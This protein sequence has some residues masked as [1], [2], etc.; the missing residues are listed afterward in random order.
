M[1]RSPQHSAQFRLV[2]MDF[3]RFG[4]GLLLNSRPFQL[5]LN[6]NT[7][8]KKRARHIQDI[9]NRLVSLT[10]QNFFWNSS[11]RVMQKSVVGPYNAE[12]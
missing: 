12:L 2:V 8:Q 9:G 4:K 1:I 11:Q 7:L 6:W 10:S 5:D 3:V